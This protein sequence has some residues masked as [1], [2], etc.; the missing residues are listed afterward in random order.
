MALLVEA[1]MTRT[2]RYRTLLIAACVVAAVSVAANPAPAAPENCPAPVPNHIPAAPSSTL[3]LGTIKE[4]LLEYHEKHYNDDVAAVF[5]SAQK[6][7]EQNAAR[8]KRPAIVFDIDETSLNNWPNLAADNFGFFAGGTCDVL[9]AGPCG[10]NQWI[11]K[12]SAKAIE[13]A[14]EL[15]KA[16]KRNGVAVIFITGRPDSQR[17]ATIV[18]LDH[19]GYDGWTELR[20]RPDRS[21]GTVQDFK[22]KER[23]KVEAEPQG[24]TIIANVGDQMSDIDGG[25]GGCTFKVPNPFYFI[26]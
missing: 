17:D 22:T 24:Y 26:R 18:N 11:L 19:A 2:D 7:V 13:P 5:A 3:N 1:N 25:H 23:I 20:T 14:R 8:A 12:S 4:L 16:A 21:E 9:P 6:F 15:F 10:F